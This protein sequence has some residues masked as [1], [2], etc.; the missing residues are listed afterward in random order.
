MDIAK[1]L[2]LLIRSRYPIIYLRT[3]EER[4][5]QNLIANIA[6]AQ[7]K[8]LMEW[9][10]T[11]GLRVVENFGEQTARPAAAGDL[12]QPMAAFETIL[13]D[14]GRTIYVLK[15]I[16]AYL[17]DRSIIRKIRDLY[18]NIKRTYKTLICLSPVKKI[19][20][21][22]EK[23]VYF[24]NMPLPDVPMLKGLLRDIGQTLKHDGRI[25][26]D[27]TDADYERLADAALGLTL[28]EAERVFFKA[29]VRDAKLAAS[30]ISYVR[31]EKRQIV[32]K[33]GLLEYYETEE[34]MG[35]VGG[36][37][38]LKNWLKQ[39]HR[40]FESS[41]RDYGLPLPKGL[42]LL[43]V[44]GCGKS[45][46]A[47][48]VSGTWGFPLLRLDM[49]RI[50]GSLIGSS[51]ENMRRAL[52]M[53]ESVSPAVLWVD[54]I[55]K[56][57]SGI[58]SSGMTDAGT[59]ARVFG[60]FLTWLQDKGSPVFCVAT[61]NSIEHLPPELLRKGRFDEIFFVDLPNEAER[62][63]IFSIHLRKRKRDAAKF[64]VQ[65]LAKVAEGL[66]GAEIEQAIVSAMYEAFDERR[67]FLPEDI[68]RS[69]RHSVPLSVTMR[70]KLDDL[71][72][73][74]RERA[75]PASER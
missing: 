9:S 32:Q 71:R 1:E 74:A 61:A 75:R 30:D 65:H 56:T 13:Q 36:L 22:L 59:T 54:E 53:A 50:F 67:E 34:A 43:G 45:L 39:R 57:F 20:H 40:A 17:D 62:A 42:L 5:A 35:T 33:S 10:S 58:E 51:E 60:S 26:I 25:T 41:A 15:D 44:Q 66:S 28:E 7:R 18:E 8:T 2:D 73:W 6:R 24:L 16:H 3:N 49:S 72:E 47:K 11:E 64:G 29:V 12:S 38:L 63:E 21:E 4:R 48:A 37:G 31:D 69:M 70:E 27:M 23:D 55:E 68:L 14:P 52:E 19:P 46:A